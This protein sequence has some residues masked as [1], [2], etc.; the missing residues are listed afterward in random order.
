MKIIR[1]LWIC[2]LLVGCS[3]I[4][5]VQSIYEEVKI[6]LP[7]LAQ[8]NEEI[9]EEVYDLDMDDIKQFAIYRPISNVEADEFILIHAHNGE[10]ESIKENLDSYFQM[11]EG[12]WK[13]VLP[14]QYQKITSRKE[15]IIDDYYCVVVSDYADAII[16]KVKELLEA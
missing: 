12:Y 8:A 6:D 13:D 11:M 16:Q 1:F 7:L 14:L 2:L 3:K 15:L 5:D 9:V 4:T 10:V